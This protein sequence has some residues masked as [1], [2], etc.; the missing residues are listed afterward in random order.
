V[1][2]AHPT[3]VRAGSGNRSI[4]ASREL[5]QANTRSYP[6]STTFLQIL[7]WQPALRKKT[8][9]GYHPINQAA[10]FIRSD[11]TLAAI[12]IKLGFAQKLGEA[13]RAIS[14][15]ARRF[16]HLPQY[17]AAILCRAPASSD[18]TVLVERLFTM[19]LLRTGLKHRARMESN[20]AQ[21]RRSG[22][23]KCC[24]KTRCLSEVGIFSK[25]KQQWQ[26]LG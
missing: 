18:T 2:A 4:P 20:N 22:G 8:R 24:T 12:L 23:R 10:S 26:E 21:I 14:V 16:T 6:R 5:R 1:N 3:T 19:H 17:F 7:E 13:A 25:E 15:A 11:P 9:R